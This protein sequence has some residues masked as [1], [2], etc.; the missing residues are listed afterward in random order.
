MP[1]TLY[2]GLEFQRTQ[3][4]IAPTSDANCFF[5]RLRGLFWESIS[6]TRSGHP[7]LV[8]TRSMNPHR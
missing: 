6:I 5:S 8:R 7:A 1:G 4:A 3:T 2:T